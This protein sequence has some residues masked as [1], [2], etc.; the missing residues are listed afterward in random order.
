MLRAK[1]P[2]VCERLE[3]QLADEAPDKPHC[4][5]EVLNCKHDL[6]AAGATKLPSW[7]E[8]AA[9]AVPPQAEEG[10]DA[11][12]LDRGW[13]CHACSCLETKFRER[14]VFPLCDEARLTLLLSQSGGPASAWLRAVP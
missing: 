2:A 1:A 13:Q 12:D 9:G 10:I 3:L 5:Q 8:A 6:V 11:A 4:V 14:V 7:A